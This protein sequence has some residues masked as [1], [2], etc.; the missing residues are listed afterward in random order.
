MLF[1]EKCVIIKAKMRERGAFVCIFA[2]YSDKTELCYD[3]SVTII[4]I[5][6]TSF[7][8]AESDGIAYEK[9]K[10]GEC[11]YATNSKKEIGC[12]DGKRQ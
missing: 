2:T 1:S 8:N 4:K 6:E 9:F 12:G 3:I 10:S 5:R 11:R 7:G